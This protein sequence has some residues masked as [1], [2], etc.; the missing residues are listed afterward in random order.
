[1]D[2]EEEISKAK[3]YIACAVDVLSRIPDTSKEYEEKRIEDC[4]RN[5][6]DIQILQL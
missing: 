2:I 5:L 4:I 6:Q 3:G 1:M